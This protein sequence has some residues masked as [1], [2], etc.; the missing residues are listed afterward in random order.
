VFERIFRLGVGTG[1]AIL[2][3]IVVLI[4]VA[5][6][7]IQSRAQ[8]T[9]SMQTTNLRVIPTLRS[10]TVSAAGVEFSHCGP[11]TYGPST[12]FTLGFP[13]WHCY[14]GKTGKLFPITIRNG[15]AA[16]IMVGASKAMP[17]DGGRPWIPCI[18]GS[19]GGEAA[20]SASGNLPGRDQYAVEIFSNYQKK[21]L[22]PGL[23]TAMQCDSR[24][25]QNGCLAATGQVQREGV[26][27]TGP[28][29]PDDNST[30]WRVTITWMAAPPS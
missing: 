25:G 5:I 10:V 9:A 17:S 30:T 6:A 23:S 1:L 18:P 4:V 26:R 22:G 28:A 12:E 21:K 20:C 11:K 3:V 27:L 14:I 13:N 8:T 2:A 29:E 15:R 19:S 16:M 7:E 24:F